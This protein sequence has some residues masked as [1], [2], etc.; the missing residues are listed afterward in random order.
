MMNTLQAV[1]EDS[2]F[3]LLV[4]KDANVSSANRGLETLSAEQ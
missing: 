2:S 1:Y 3:R 4:R